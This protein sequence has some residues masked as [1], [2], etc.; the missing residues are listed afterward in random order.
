[1]SSWRSWINAAKRE[2]FDFIAK[3][4][5]LDCQ[6]KKICDKHS[7]QYVYSGQSQYCL[8][9]V[10]PLGSDSYKRLYLKRQKTDLKPA[11]AHRYEIVFNE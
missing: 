7:Q 11:S 6:Y 1:M 4:M 9:L 10:C 5:L 3:Q 2:S 8:R